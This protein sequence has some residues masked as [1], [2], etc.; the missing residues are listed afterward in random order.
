MSTL[1]Q[2]KRFG[3]EFLDQIIDWIAANLEPDDVFSLETLLDW[4][5][6]NGLVSEDD[7]E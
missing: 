2:D 5:N 7:D 6:Y 4:A 3:R 1:E